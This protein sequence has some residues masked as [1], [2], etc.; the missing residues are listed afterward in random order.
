MDRDGLVTAYHGVSL[1]C[2]RMGLR[3]GVEPLLQNMHIWSKRE[4]YGSY[5]GN[6]NI[7]TMTS[8]YIFRVVMYVRKHL[9]QIPS[10]G[11]THA[12][13]ARHGTL[14]RTP[15]H[16]LSLHETRVMHAGVIFYNALSQNLKE[17]AFTTMI[18]N[19]AQQQNVTMSVTENVNRPSPQALANRMHLQQLSR[20]C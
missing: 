3:S 4:L 16:R 11:S 18:Q 19:T 2:W 14:L 17:A 15:S 12:Y 20:H 5:A 8:L 1:R 9:C 10:V 7:L 6:L 13:P